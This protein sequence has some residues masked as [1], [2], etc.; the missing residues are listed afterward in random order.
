M[1][2]Q[3]INVKFV[4]LFRK[5]TFILMG[6]LIIIVFFLSTILIIINSNKS[7]QQPDRTW[8]IELIYN[9]NTKKI[10]L[11]NLTVISRKTVP[12]QRNALYSPFKLQVL[13]KNGNVIFQEKVNITEQMVYGIFL[14]APEG[15]LPISTD[16]K[17][18]IFVPFQTDASKII[19]LKNSD[20]VLQINLPKLTS[21]DFIKSVQAA[22]QSVSCGPITTVFINDNYT[23]IEQFKSDVIYLKNLYNTTAPYNIT[24]SIFDFQ[25]VDNPQGFGCAKSGLTSCMDNYSGAMKSAGLKYFPN[26]QKFIVLVDNPNAFIMDGGIAG[27]VNGQGGDVIIYTNYAD[28]GLGPIS[29]KP[30]AA[31]AHELEGHAVGYLWDRYVSSDL[32]YGVI[33]DGDSQSN[34][35]T[36]P[37]GQKDWPNFGVTNPFPIG[38]SNEKQYAPFPLTC[39]SNTKAL[40]SGGT[41]DSIMGAIGCAPNQFDQVE[42]A[43]IKTQILPNYKPCP[44]TPISTPTP[45][46]TSTLMPTPTP[47]PTPTPVPTPT[48]NSFPVLTMPNSTTAPASAQTYNCVLDSSC[49][50]ARN[51]IQ[52][53]PLKC[54]PN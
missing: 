9:S 22:Q 27:L 10:S 54:T 8:Q 14:N 3:E 33:A 13:G 47:T 53:C 38:C 31:A 24:P 40:I 21:F 2:V 20:T 43:W 12:D 41:N 46:S 11:E 7:S 36:S 6:L 32:N 44:K 28:S 26:A 34:C 35:S 37:Q 4:N 49:A 29:G 23:N 48:I 16:I 51:S 42:Q 19:I 39:R 5:K 30:F 15:K 25:E 45:I 50:S 17:S 1:N 18:V 52:M